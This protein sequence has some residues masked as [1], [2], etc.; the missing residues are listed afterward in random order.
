M[1]QITLKETIFK[2]IEIPM[3]ALYDLV[4][5]LPEEERKKWL[6]RLKAKSITLI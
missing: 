4:D 1:P 2:K 5:N 6:Q 3:D